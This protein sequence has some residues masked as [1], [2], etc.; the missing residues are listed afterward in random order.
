METNEPRPENT[1]QGKRRKS[2]LRYFGY[3]RQLVVWGIGLSLLLILLFQIPAFQ[4]WIGKQVVN[5]IGETLGTE[6]RLDRVNLAWFDA[7]SLDGLYVEDKYGDTLLYSDAIRADFNFNPLILLSRGLE[8]EELE[9]SNTRFVIRRDVGD[10]ESNLETALE[11]LFPPKDEPSKPL[12][13]NLQRLQLRN[14]S[15]IQNDSVRGQ[16]M[17]LELQEAAIRLENLDLP[18]KRIELSDVSIFEPRYVLT[19]F[20]PSPLDENSDPLSLETIEM[21]DSISNAVDQ[22]DSL[23]LE[24][25]VDNVEIKDGY[26]QLDNYRKDPIERSDLTA[27]DFARLGVSDIDLEVSDLLMR[28][29]TFTGQLQHLSLREKSGFIIDKLSVGD[30]TVAPTR[31]IAND[32]ELLT[33]D[34]RLSDTLDFTY[35]R[36]WEDWNDFPNRVNMRLNF[37]ESRVALRD[38]MYFARKLRSNQFFR[39]NRRRAISLDGLIRGRV[40]SLKGEAL[41]LALDNENYLAGDFELTGV[42]R[43]G[44]TFLQLDLEQAVTDMGTLR[45]LIENFNPPEAF[46]RL[47]QLRFSGNFD[48]FI[49]NFVAYGDLRTDIGRAELNMQ[50]NLTPGVAAAE[51]Q[52]DLLLENFD[53]GMFLNKPEFGTVSLSGNIADGRGLVAETAAA[54]LN[55]T[56]DNFTFRDYNYRQA[57]ISGQLNRNFFNGSFDIRDENIDFNFLGEL[58]FRDSIA[59]FDFAA[60]VARLDLKALNL[61]K[62]DLVISGLI[63]LNLRNTKFSDMEGSVNIGSLSLV[64]DD[65]EVYDID[66]VAA[67]SSFDERGRKLV[68]LESDVAT[69]RLVGEFDLDQVVGSLK[70]FMVNNYPGF[71][72]RLNLEPPRRISSGNNFSYELEIIDSKGLNY[73][74]APTLGPIRGLVVAGNYNEALEEFGFEVE[75]PDLEIGKLR[76]ND[77]ILLATSNGPFGEISLVVDSTYNNGKPLLGQVTFLSL[78]EGDSLDFGINYASDG[79]L[80]DKV[81]LDGHFFLPDSVNYRLTFDSSRLVLFQ[82]IWEISGENAITFRKGYIDTRNFHLESGRRRISLQ[83]EGRRGLGLD[84]RNFELGL[85]DSLWNYPNLDFSGDFSAKVTVQDLFKMEGL[86]ANLRADTFLMNDDDYGWMR[87]DATVPDLR[88]Q[89]NAYL[90]LNRDT[91]QLITEAVFNL[92]DL[93]ENPTS[94]EQ[95]KNYLDLNVAIDGYPLELA[96][97]WVGGSVSDIEGEFNA[98]M[99]VK[100]L[101][102]RLDVDGFIK[103]RNGAFTIDYLKTRYRFDEAPVAI[104]NTLFDASGTVLR[105]RYGNSASVR[106]GISHNR[107][108]N[109]GLDAELFTD[110]FL[111]LDLEKEDNDLFYGRALGKG[112][113]AFSG[114]FRQTDI[115]VRAEV[116]RDSYLFIPTDQTAEAGPI[117][118]IRFVNKKVYV[119][120][121]EEELRDPTGVSLE[122]ELIIN[123]QAQV[124]IIFDEEIGD[125]IRGNGRGNL[126]ITVPRDGDMQMFGDYTIASGN[127]LFTFYKVVNKLFSVRPG[128]S[129]SWSGDPFGAQINL[130]ADYEKLS[131]PILNFIQ[132]YLVG[133]ADQGLQSDAAR[134]TEVNLTL[135]LQG[136]LLQPDINFD[137]SFPQ[138]EGRLETFANN[139]RRLLLM[140]QNELN[141]QVFGLIVVGQFLPADLSFST[142]DVAVNTISEWL[143]NYFSL[144]LNNLLTDTFG[145]DAFISS[146]DF[147]LAY[148]RYN[149][150]NLSADGLNSRGDVFEFTIRKSL[151]NRWTIVSDISVLSNNQLAA[152]G[153][154]QTFIGNN[155]ALEYAFND[156]RT[157]KLR[158]YQRITPDIVSTARNQ[159]GLGLSWRKEFNSLKEFF[160]KMKEEVPQ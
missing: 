81:D 91:S 64:K 38:I 63:D 148:N 130:K 50:M 1:P 119:E 129:I 7:L 5:S 133:N 8:I 134:A 68:V 115:Y 57:E 41:E 32:I 123:E 51:Y 17:D 80:L 14:I 137:L 61:S 12:N 138:L 45:S 3:L 58:D 147:D 144:L 9:I 26:F 49:T 13:L 48:G 65:T 92:Q 72:E 98:G 69:G 131:T 30:L 71:A 16:R 118:D 158:F 99:R 128:G 107:L 136:Q 93:T 141:R 44:E 77:I 108:K 149:S 112:R 86:S 76:I 100:G 62:A 31:L 21:M 85:I 113:I 40:N 153:N 83:R 89:V 135:I 88:G 145:E 82:D 73:L 110:R 55:A 79:S 54:G 111:A 84:L 24:V 46:N 154:S 52:G 94:N 6:V 124:E 15:F 105:D 35:R 18:G 146:F 156:A 127:Y 121:E 132:E 22:L 75:V 27:I 120:P 159:V 114:N 95:R 10:A 29:D 20:Q 103:A 116:G 11:K 43:P 151:G 143:S 36:G 157:L 37:D 70:Q 23:K 97:Y 101:T 42:T 155:F 160:G 109:L 25:I 47:G 96:N 66:T 39:D 139:K 142:Q 4:N 106:G 140:D 19:N 2:K 152:S 90:S 56:I 87:L 33:P 74:I 60:E 34:S 28:R 59:D 53:V 67:Y 104:N 125:L 117:S 150:G 122:M 78:L 126:R 102:N